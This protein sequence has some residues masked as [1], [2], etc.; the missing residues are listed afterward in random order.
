[1]LLIVYGYND[2]CV[3]SC[4]VYLLTGFKRNIMQRTAAQRLLTSMK[5][6]GDPVRK[7]THAVGGV[8]VLQTMVAHKNEELKNLS[9]SLLA[10]LCTL[11][12]ARKELASAPK[13]ASNAVGAACQSIAKGDVAAAN[14][15]AALARDTSECRPLFLAACAEHK[16][17]RVLLDGSTN[18]SHSHEA[19]ESC[20]DALEALCDA[21][22]ASGYK[23]LAWAG[24][25]AK[26]AAELG[27]FLLNKCIPTEEAED[28]AAFCLSLNKKKATDL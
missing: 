9:T 16:A 8:A 22:P 17:V 1:M 25:L 14:L 6:Y 11:P 19:R 26:I 24:G 21:D 7:A 5:T 20:V 4:L 2:N 12:E 27:T 3:D 15:L 10:E 13:A 23:K 18:H 28:C